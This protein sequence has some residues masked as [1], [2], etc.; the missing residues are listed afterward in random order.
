MADAE[1]QT[2][3]GLFEQQKKVTIENEYF[4]VGKI[5]FGILNSI[6]VNIFLLIVVL[7]W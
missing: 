2:S 5:S 7:S 1:V 4:S 3:I 6:L